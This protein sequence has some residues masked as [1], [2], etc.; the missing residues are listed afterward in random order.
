[1]HFKNN[2]QTAENNFS[3]QSLVYKSRIKV[4]CL[5]DLFNRWQK[6]PKG[7][8]LL[9]QLEF[10]DKLLKVSLLPYNVNKLHAKDKQ[11][12]FDPKN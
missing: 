1:M 6:Y 5:C 9:P 11:T 2:L 10:V 12:N 4:L 8:Q 3:K 7:K